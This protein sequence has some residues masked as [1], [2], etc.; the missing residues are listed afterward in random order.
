M[1]DVQQGLGQHVQ[2]E[3]QT[4]EEAAVAPLAGIAALGT[5]TARVA[6]AVMTVAALFAGLLSGLFG[7]G[8]GSGAA[9]AV[10]AAAGL[11]A[12]AAQAA[13]AAHVT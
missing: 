5:G 11:H 13:L 3:V 10:D 4:G 2:R 9:L 6:A 7:Q 12:A 8:R 1:R